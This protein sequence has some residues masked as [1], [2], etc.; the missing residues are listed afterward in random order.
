MN[1]WICRILMVVFFINTLPVGAWAGRRKQTPKFNQQALAKKI[2][3]STSTEEDLKQEK[4]ELEA[5]LMHANLSPRERK[6]T[7][8]ELKI[9]NTRLEWLHVVTTSNDIGDINS[10][11]AVL[12]DNKIKELQA[13]E[14]LVEKQEAFNDF[15][16][17]ADSLTWIGAAV[18]ALH[19]A[20]KEIYDSSLR[21]YQYDQKVSELKEQKRT[22]AGHYTNPT[23]A[24][25]ANQQAVPAG[26]LINFNSEVFD[27]WEQNKID[28][29]DLVEY[30]DPVDGLPPA[31]HLM[32]VAD[33]AELLYIFFLSYNS[34]QGQLVGE[35]KDNAL[36]VAK[37]IKVRATRQLSIYE[38]YGL[39]EARTNL[40]LLLIQVNAFLDRY[41][42]ETEQE[43]KADRERPGY[44]M[45]A[46]ELNEGMNAYRAWTYSDMTQNIYNAIL[47]EIAAK[48]SQDSAA[49]EYL[50]RDLA[51]AVSYLFTLDN[52][53]QLSN[54]LVQINKDGKTFHGYNEALVTEF[55]SA[56]YNILLII[57]TSHSQQ[58]YVQNLL[59][60]AASSKARYGNDT[61][62]SNAVNVRV[63]ALALASVLKQAADT[64]TVKIF[65]SPKK[66][67]LPYLE[68]GLFTNADFRQSMADYAV[69][70]YAPTVE[71]NV[72][73]RFYS[74]I[75]EHPIERYGMQLSELQELSNHLTF[76]FRSFLPVYE[77]NAVWSKEVTGQFKG[78][79]TRG[80]LDSPKLMQEA[81]LLRTDNNSHWQINPVFGDDTPNTN[82]KCSDHPSIVRFGIDTVIVWDSTH[83]NKWAMKYTTPSHDRIA[84]EDMALSVMWE[85]VTWYMWGAMFKV[86]GYVGKAS[87]AAIIAT[88][89]T[90]KARNGFRMAR[91]ESKFSQVWKYSTGAWQQ[92]LGVASVTKGGK[93][94]VGKLFARQSA[95]GE[96]Y[97]VDVVREGFEKITLEIPA[98]GISLRTLKGRVLLNRAIQRELRE[99]N[100][101]GRAT[102]STIGKAAGTTHTVKQTLDHAGQAAVRDEQHLVQAVEKELASGRKFT[103][104]ETTVGKIVTPT[105]SKLINPGSAL[106]KNLTLDAATNNLF[107][108]SGEYVGTVLSDGETAVQVANQVTKGLVQSQSA[109][110][111]SL[112]GRYLANTYPITKEMWGI[113]KLMIA[114]KIADPFVYSL[115]TKPYNE[116]FAKRQDDYFSQKHGVDQAALQTQD[117]QTSPAG[118]VLTR[119]Q[120]LQPKEEDTSWAAFSGIFLGANQVLNTFLPQWLQEGRR[121]LFKAT[122]QV[123]ETV[124]GPLKDLLPADQ[125]EAF[126]T[127]TQVALMPGVLLGDPTPT[128]EDGSAADEQYRMTAHNQRLK[129]V[130]DSHDAKKIQ[131]ANEKEIQVAQKD[132]D[133]TLQDKDIKA[134][135]NAI[136]TG[137]KEMKTA[138]NTYIQALKAATQLAQ[139][140]LK[141]SQKAADDAFSKFIN[142]KAGI[143]TRGIKAF[144]ATEKPQTLRAQHELFEGN[145]PNYFNKNKKAQERLTSII[146]NYYA[147]REEV[148]IAFYTADNDAL[149]TKQPVQV[150]Q[151]AATKQFA[152][153]EEEV[154]KELEALQKELE[155]AYFAEQLDKEIKHLK[156]D[157]SNTNTIRE[158]MSDEN[159]AAFIGALPDG[160]KQLKMIYKTYEQIL[161]RA[162]DVLNENYDEAIKIASE[163]KDALL[164]SRVNLLCQGI[165]AYAKTNQEQ[166]TTSLINELSEY[167]A[168]F[169]TDEDREALAQA[170]SFYW[171]NW[172]EKVKGIYR[173]DVNQELSED[174]IK[175]KQEV[176]SLGL[177]ALQTILNEKISKIQEAC[178]ERIDSFE[179]TR[180]AK[181]K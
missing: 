102:A 34:N 30:L 54:I 109:L 128:V 76:I 79:S 136:P 112:I 142:T 59:Q 173:L 169:F 104:V 127:P 92:E 2:E 29:E 126:P 8:L 99:I 74:D 107:S 115:Y 12:Y 88:K 174:D 162:K 114:F 155:S 64:H 133:T 123:I 95:Q 113:T 170:I 111:P 17:Q 70:V 137:V 46:K 31:N 21:V 94:M 19:N 9:V 1:T 100:V 134:F 3:H 65:E 27:L 118:N 151:E 71:W 75:R 60:V 45:I 106:P 11:I 181:Q 51:A 180:Q 158:Y 52:Q 57:P 26:D 73:R 117:A 87:K 160:E 82:I 144:L 93:N 63:Q 15:Y 140:D 149:K 83:S 110:S 125:R 25:P 171:T 89:T 66:I 97:V 154:R 153:I 139:T 135:L 132:L 40:T 130:M 37:R 62:I 68:A 49:Y 129:K 56:I 131:A 116:K 85:A 55:F 98:K 35:E 6:F 18:G 121:W 67:D 10:R 152:A 176:L 103:V 24:I 143:L 69:E 179:R 178:N 91:F 124:D 141:G 145:F 177:E 138:Y 164:N 81:D 16:Q 101:A 5:S 120:G 119:V 38:H 84:M 90:A 165:D 150:L 47:K 86:L 36:W 72:G 168:I 105:G 148:L 167:Y 22:L 122:E 14:K 44:D 28:M 108:T 43:K 32:T 172:T 4:A 78:C 146:N 33:A 77:P 48:P 53:A 80:F 159:V 175:I 58:S 157:E 96:Y 39:L 161:K 7:E 156:G 50:R 20:A 23:D 41:Y 42:K 163:A 147:K 166:T 61:V 13:S